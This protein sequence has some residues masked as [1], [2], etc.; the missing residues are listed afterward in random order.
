[1]NH[2][3][4]THPFLPPTIHLFVIERELHGP[5]M[6]RLLLR[7]RVPRRLGELKCLPGASAFDLWAF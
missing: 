4:D 5:V 7:G 1:M 6:N 2:E 3:A